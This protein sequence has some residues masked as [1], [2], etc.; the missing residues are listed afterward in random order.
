VRSATPSA[1]EI[2]RALESTVLLET[3]RGPVVMRMLPEA[4]LSAT[5]FVGLV[6][7]GFYDGL[8]FHRVVPNFVAQG[9][10]PRGDGSGG[11]DALVREEISRVPHRRGTVGMATEGKDTG[12]SQFFFNEG[13]NANLDGHYTVF[14]EVVWGMENAERLEVGDV[15]REARV[16]R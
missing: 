1:R 14:A 13:W 3:T 6:K 5:N 7:G 2:E 15:I 8:P 16:I 4:P 12:S 9:G 11:S 10:D